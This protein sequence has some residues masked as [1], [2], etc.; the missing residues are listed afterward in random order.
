MKSRAFIIMTVILAVI[1]IAAANF[2]KI[3]DLFDNGPDKIGIASN[4]PKIAQMVK[5]Q[6]KHIEEKGTEFKILSK[7]QVLKEIKKDKIDKAY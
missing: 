3:I 1:I 6:S 5:A 4:E 7:E 2:N